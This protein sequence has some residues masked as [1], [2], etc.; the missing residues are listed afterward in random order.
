MNSA[1]LEK[2][3]LGEQ[4]W[5]WAERRATEQLLWGVFAALNTLIPTQDTKNAM[6]AQGP[7]Q[8]QWPLTV[9]SVQPC[10]P[11]VK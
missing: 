7:F 2:A 5:G 4:V 9:D 10:C 3:A 8:N 1:N 6:W 11:A